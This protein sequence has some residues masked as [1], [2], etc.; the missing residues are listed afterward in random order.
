MKPAGALVAGRR[1]TA[2][3]RRLEIAGLAL[4]ASGCGMIPY[5]AGYSPHP[6]SAGVT[7]GDS[8]GRVVGSGVFVEERKGVRILIDLKGVAPG[9]KAVHI[10]EVGRCDPPSFDSAGTHFNPGKTVHGS[11]NPR[12]PHAGD[13]PNITVDSAGQGHLEFT[14]RRITLGKGATSLFDPDGSALVVHEQADDL[15]TDP[16]GASGARVA[17]GIIVRGG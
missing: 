8:S 7:I 4:L 10:H 16:D 12:G 14:D 6:P 5:V 3:R 15:R 9:I 17:C 2:A 11:T 1:S 13:L